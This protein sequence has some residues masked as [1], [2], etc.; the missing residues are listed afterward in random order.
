MKEVDH[1]PNKKK[2][3][4]K[5]KFLQNQKFTGKITIYYQISNRF[6]LK[7]KITSRRNLN[8]T[9]VVKCIAVFYT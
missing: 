9:P 5:F 8:Y 6:L 7:V 1:W 4:H 2:N 3:Y